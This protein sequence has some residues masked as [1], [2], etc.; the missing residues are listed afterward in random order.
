MDTFCEKFN[1]KYNASLNKSTISRYENM[2][3]EPM[4]S[5]AKNIADFFG[6]SP[7]ELLGYNNKPHKYSISTKDMVLLENI[8]R[9]SDKDKR[10]IEFMISE[11][12]LN[13]KKPRKNK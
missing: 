1:K 4:L 5:T 6:I 10:M 3:Q 13:D 2:A 9:L 11:N 12:K 8:K 7:S